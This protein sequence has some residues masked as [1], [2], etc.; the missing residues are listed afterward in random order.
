MKNILL[1]AIAATVV[2]SSGVAF[3]ETTTD[4]FLKSV[5]EKETVQASSSFDGFDAK[6]NLANGEIGVNDRQA[7]TLIDGLKVSNN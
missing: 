6:A 7:S 2:L 3:A 5:F 1:S 4:N